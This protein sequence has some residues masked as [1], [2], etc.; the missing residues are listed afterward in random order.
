MIIKMNPVHL[1]DV[2]ELAGD[3]ENKPELKAY[4]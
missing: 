3:L 2:E 1:A 4:L